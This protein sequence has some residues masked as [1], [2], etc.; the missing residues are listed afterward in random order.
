MGYFKPKQEE[1]NGIH[2]V[3]I[4]GEDARDWVE[5]RDFDQDKLRAIES[6][7]AQL[8]ASGRPKDWFF[9]TLLVV[10][11]PSSGNSLG[12]D[13]NL[14]T[15]MCGEGDFYAVPSPNP[16]RKSDWDE[17]LE[18]L[19]GPTG[20]LA[21]CD[22]V[23]GQLTQRLGSPCHKR[24]IVIALPYPGINQTMFG[25]LEEGGANLNFSVVGQTLQRAT[26]QRLEAE[27]WFVRE[28]HERWTAANFKNLNFLGFYWMFETVYR[29]W[30]ID[31]HYLLKELRRTIN[32]LGYK[33]LWI[34]FWSTYNVHLLD[35]YSD[36]YFDLAFVQPNYMFYRAIQGVEEAAQVARTRGAG[37]ELEYFVQ[38]PE[39]IQTK[40]ERHHRF[41]EYLDGGVK[42]GYMTESV[43]AYFV[44]GV[45]SMLDLHKHPSPLERQT[46]EA[47]C[48]FTKG[49]YRVGD[50]LP[51]E[52][53]TKR[54]GG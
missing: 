32:E 24:N 40:A 45:R 1:W 54:R 15:T 27:R 52:G 6:N 19:Y 36:Y 51:D 28:A 23:L 18:A 4:Q 26:D 29:S 22:H 33:F 9:D 39:P 49:T 30:D 8:D 21:A 2:H 5:K 11:V 25:S 16:T 34:P 20:Y 7:F 53:N 43:C 38:L 48:A 12:A 31:D 3:Y 35:N 14:G 46:Y 42:Y 17:M 37:I 13:V 50:Y 10:M 44:G 47:L 41:K